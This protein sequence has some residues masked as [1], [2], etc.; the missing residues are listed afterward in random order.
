M[1][2]NIDGV[3]VV[4]GKEDVSYL[5]SFINS[6]FFATNGSDI[7]QKKI[8]FLQEVS[9][10]NKIY[11]LTDNDDAGERIRKIIKQ[12]INGVFDLKI[13]GFARK[14]Y[15]KHGVA[16][17]SKEEIVN[18]LK[19]YAQKEE[20]FYEDYDLVNLISLSDNPGKKREEIISK[21]RLIDGNNKYL[22]NQLRMLKI[23]KE[24]LWK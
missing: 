14:N 19:D 22:E 20:I 1:K 21:Y 23:S 6:L 12:E 15:R 11:V 7:N 9:K 16:E 4:E 18:L 5:S 2:I 13:K 24:E 3:I 17:S 8:N 10:V